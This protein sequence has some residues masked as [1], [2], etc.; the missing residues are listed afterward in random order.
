MPPD[1]EVPKD[2]QSSITV[3]PSASAHSMP[4]PPLPAKSTTP[5][6]QESPA[7]SIQ[8]SRPSPRDENSPLSTQQ[9]KR[10]ANEQLS[11]ECSV[12]NWS[13]EQPERE[14]Q[15]LGEPDEVIDALDWRDLGE[16]Y[17]QSVDT[18]NQR[19]GEIMD[20]YRRLCDVSLLL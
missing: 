7:Q 10:A 13:N 2:I 18:L 5:R 6:S 4:P 16:R 1:E 14:S 17:H 15:D 3:M 12:I 19:E 20:E 8:S 9:S 11:H